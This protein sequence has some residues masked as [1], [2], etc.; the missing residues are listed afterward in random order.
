[1]YVI[2]SLDHVAITVRDMDE[3]VEF[4]TKRLGL[5]VTRR[6][7]TPDANIVY[8]QAGE[9]KIELFGLKKEKTI[10][11]PPIETRTLGLKHIAFGVNDL[12]ETAI[13]FKKLGIKF[14][15]G[16]EQTKSGLFIAFFNDPNGVSIELI[17][18]K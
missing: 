4:Y 16:P 17:Q 11:A 9:I 6:M 12:Q 13:R 7:E 10:E 15:R 3:S 18:S 5:S 14:V 2:G 1:M 8:L